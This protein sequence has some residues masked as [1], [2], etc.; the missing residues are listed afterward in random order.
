M[1][2]NSLPPLDIEPWFAGPEPERSSVMVN[3]LVWFIVPIIVS[4]FLWG[5]LRLAY[6][7]ASDEASSLVWWSVAVPVVFFGLMF[8]LV[9][10]VTP[11]LLLGKLQ[12]NRLSGRMRGYA[13][14]TFPG[15]FSL[16]LFHGLFCLALVLTMAL[17]AVYLLDPSA[18]VAA[19]AADWRSPFSLLDRAA[20]SLYSGSWLQLFAFTYLYMLLF[21]LG[22]EILSVRRFE[23]GRMSVER[24]DGFAPD[25]AARRFATVAHLT[26]LHITAGD[27]TPRIDGGPGGNKQLRRVL[28]QLGGGTHEELSAVLITGDMTDAGTADE[29]RRFF[30]LFPAELL[31]KSVVVPGNHELN[32]PQG[33]GKHAA[34]E[35]MEQIERKV[36]V[37]RFIAA[38]DRVQGARSF[39]ADESAPGSTLRP[40][41]AYLAERQAD[42]Q[43]FLKFSHLDKRERESVAPWRKLGIDPATRGRDAEDA[44]SKLSELPYRVFDEIFPMLVEVPGTELRVVVLNSNDESLDLLTN[45]YG[46]IGRPQIRRL[47]LMLEGLSEKPYVIAMHHHL[48]VPALGRTLKDRI[49]ERAMPVIDGGSLV[50]ALD[51][52]GCIVFN[53]HRHVSYFARIGERIQIVSGPSTTLG[54]E[55]PPPRKELGFG[56]YELGWDG[57][58]GTKCLAERW[59]ALA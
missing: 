29:W 46:L 39:V 2:E 38:A 21:W 59:C 23:F 19:V 3:V 58:S 55:S 7:R 42:L 45:A 4:L 57:R 33:K 20:V 12:L 28:A 31:A 37:I 54:D 26:D 49:F 24:V 17:L 11:Y 43:L 18:A 47:R 50:K 6:V 36:R 34:V 13:L 1:P 53:G 22:A 9:F 10:F 52:A 16:Y 40:L 41:R 44:W 35:P 5:G 8:T 14:G 32:I 15:R 30:E 56:V 25:D 51:G 27:E 48:G